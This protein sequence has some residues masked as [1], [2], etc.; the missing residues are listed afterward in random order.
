MTATCTH[1]G[2]TIEKDD[3]GVWIDLEATGDDIVW[4]EMC[5]SHDTFT[6]EHEPTL[7]MFS[8][9][10]YV[11]VEA[12]DVD[13]AQQIAAEVAECMYHDDRARNVDAAGPIEQVEV[14]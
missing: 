4:R 12:P 8:K 3:N 2:R 9:T 5:Q 14:Q 1:C 13:A 11:E 7:F 6:A 10:V